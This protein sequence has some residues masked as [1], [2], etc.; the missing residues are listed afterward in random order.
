MSSG[1]PSVENGQSCDEN[2]VSRTSGSCSSVADPHVGA[3]IGI[4]PG[5]RHVAVGAVPRRDPVA[6]P[7]L[8]RDVPVAQVVQPA[9]RTRAASGPGQNVMRPSSAASFAGPRQPIDR[10]EPLQARDPRLDLAVTPVAM[11]HGVDVRPDPPR[12][13]GRASRAPRAPRR[14][15]RSG[16]ARRT[17]PAA[18]S[19]IVASALKMFMSGSPARCAMSKSIGSCAGV[20]FTAP[21]P[22]AGSIAASATIGISRPS[23]GCR[24]VLPIRFAYRSSSGCTAIPVSPS[25]VST[26][27][28]AHVDRPAAVRQADSGT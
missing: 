3:R 12:R 13:S 11:A 14:A 24:T 1:H 2:H 8:P 20:T 22:N 10:D 21:V 9:R 23:N 7:E 5:D 6:P 19:L 25:I 26:R 4:L 18:F 28:V 16:R 27:V 15:R 17:P